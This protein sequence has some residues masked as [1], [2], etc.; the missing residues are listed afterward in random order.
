LKQANSNSTVLGSGYSQAS[1]QTQPLEHNHLIAL[2]S[3]MV[4]RNVFCLVLMMWTSLYMV[5]LLYK[6]RRRV[7]Y[8]HRASLSS[9]PSP[10]NKATHSII[11]LMTSFILFYFLHSFTSLYRLYM[12]EENLCLEK[13]FL[14]LSLCY[15]TICPFVLMKNNKILSTLI[16]S[17]LLIF[18]PQRSLSR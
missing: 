12:T 4:I 3:V 8:V 7:Q 10:E 9:Q 14:I 18:F 13:I 15:P 2:T 17:L 6:H 11:F 1:C 16:S 5:H